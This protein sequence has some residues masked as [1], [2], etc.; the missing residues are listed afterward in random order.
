MAQPSAHDRGMFALA[1]DT[2]LAHGCNPVLSEWDVNDNAMR[3]RLVEFLEKGC[4]SL[5]QVKKTRRIPLGSRV[6]R[7]VEDQI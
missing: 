7:T 5:F 1:C 4:I 3:K 6:R 2:D